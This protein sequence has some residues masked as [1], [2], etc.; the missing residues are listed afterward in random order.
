M[1]RG[2]RP[3]VRLMGA[4]EQAGVPMEALAPARGPDESTS[5]ATTSCT[6]RRVS[7]PRRRTPRSAAEAEPRSRRGLPGCTR[8][9][10]W[11]SRRRE[12]PAR[13][14]MT[15]DPCGPSLDLLAEIED[16]TRAARPA[17]LRRGRPSLDGGRPR[18]LRRSRRAAGYRS[19]VRGSRRTSIG[20]PPRALDAARSQPARLAAWLTERHVTPRHRRVQRR[21]DGTASRGRRHRPEPRAATPRHRVRRPDRVHADDP[22]ARRRGGRRAVAA[23]RRSRADRGRATTA[24]GSSSCWA[25][26][27]CCACR[28]PERAVAATVEL[29]TRARCRRPPE[30]P[31]RASTTARSSSAKATSS[32]GPS[33]SRR[34]CPTG[35]PMAAIYV[36]ADGGRG[37]R[38]AA[39]A[40]ATIGRRRGPAGHRRRSSS[41]RLEPAPRQPLKTRWTSRRPATSASMSVARRVDVE[42]TRGRSR[43]GPGARGAAS[44]SGGRPGPRSRSDPGPGRRRAGGC[45]AG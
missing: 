37:D 1:T 21:D 14:P 35:P 30:R 43:R 10:A 36:T 23:T 32:G 29:L 26:G 45:P 15:S 42:A 8:P 18:R 2:R 5:R 44:C 41:I 22:G 11:P 31:R 20:E 39:V 27:R 38:A 40:V 24:G 12:A 6:G 17:A 3:S 19:G 25:T 9:S 34:G 16:R 4:F 28:M 33:T 13:R 7:S